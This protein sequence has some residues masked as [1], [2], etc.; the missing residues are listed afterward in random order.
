MKE[1]TNNEQPDIEPQVEQPDISAQLSEIEK[2]ATNVTTKKIYTQIDALL[3]SFG[4]REEG[5]KTMQA[6][7]RLLAKPLSPEP[8]PPP[9][10]APDESK[11]I[12][13]AQIE[14]QK[15]QNEELLSRIDQQ[16]AIIEGARRAQEI[17]SALTG[18]ALA[19]PSGI[20]DD[21]K[22]Q[23]I[24]SIKAMI[25]QGVEGVAR[26]TID[27][28]TYYFDGDTPLI[29]SSTGEAMT[30]AELIASRFGHFFSVKSPLT[31]KQLEVLPERQRDE[32]AKTQK[33]STYEEAKEL[34]A[35]TH[36]RGSASWAKL[37][38]EICKTSGVK[39]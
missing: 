22:A 25:L 23:Y 1:E 32:A 18:K 29:S 10:E 30:T 3:D 5:E 37:V 4:G 9:S 39:I 16:K 36:T 38:N 20:P 19:V 2:R 17:A 26:K 7:K 14:A 31:T 11:K 33:V 34:A 15:K 27:G 13:E 21:A 8:A 12:F 35:K 28:K 24:D 6:L